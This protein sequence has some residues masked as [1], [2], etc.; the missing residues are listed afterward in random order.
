MI[1]YVN[2]NVVVIVKFYSENG[3][4]YEIIIINN[5][6]VDEINEVLKLIEL[7]F[8]IVKLF[9]FYILV[10][11]GEML[12]VGDY[13]VGIVIILGGNIVVDLVFVYDV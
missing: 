2:L 3:V 1:I 4:G 9:K 13:K 7:L 5:E 8:E 11:V 10:K 6:K 12:I